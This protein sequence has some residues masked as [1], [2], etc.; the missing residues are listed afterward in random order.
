M[1][2]HAPVGLAPRMLAIPQM[3]G[4]KSEEPQL[5][6]DAV[7]SEKS[8]ISRVSELD[9]FYPV[10]KKVV[11]LLAVPRDDCNVAIIPYAFRSTDSID[12]HTPD[13]DAK[14]APVSE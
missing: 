10:F 3:K 12:I 9:C 7:F 14:P 13:D 2:L 11:V 8:E 5:F 4:I 1:V 6:R